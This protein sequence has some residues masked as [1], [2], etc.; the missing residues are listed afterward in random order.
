[1][2]KVILLEPGFGSSSTVPSFFLPPLQ[3]LRPFL[4]PNGILH[5]HLCLLPSFGNCGSQPR[6][7][8]LSTVH[9]PPCFKPI[10]SQEISSYSIFQPFSETGSLWVVI[11]LFPSSFL[12]FFPPFLPSCLL[13]FPSSSLPSLSFPLILLYI[14][15]CAIYRVYNDN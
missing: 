2:S 11:H 7:S 15:H 14:K 13:F 9:Q 3:I 6:S 12:S 5:L 8:F 10:E 4:V 1:M